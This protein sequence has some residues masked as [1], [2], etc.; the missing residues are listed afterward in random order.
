MTHLLD[1]IQSGKPSVTGAI[2]QTVSDESTAGHFA[3]NNVG[4]TS[5]GTGNYSA[6]DYYI[7]FSGT[8]NYSGLASISSDTITLPKGTYFIK[9]IP[10]FGDAGPTTTGNTEL[11]AQFVDQD[12]NPLGNLGAVNRDI[13]ATYPSVGIF[14]AYVEGPA[15]VKLKIT[16]VTGTFPKDETGTNLSA[17]FLDIMRIF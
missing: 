2:T 3:V 8:T 16:S 17:Y 6:S 11:R 4:Q 5:G 14:T 13:Y 1:Q 10:T 7:F 15:T 12:D 9:C